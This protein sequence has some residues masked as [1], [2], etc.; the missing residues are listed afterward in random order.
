MPRP[1]ILLR[2]L[3]LLLALPAC[4][5]AGGERP[6][7]RPDAGRLQR[8]VAVLASDAYEGRGTG[9]PGADSAAAWLVRRYRALGIAPGV[10][11]YL[12]PFTVRPGGHAGHVPLLARN[13]VAVIPGTDAALR[14][15]Y[16]VLGAHYDHLGRSKFGAND[17]EAGGAIRNGADDNAS[18]TAAVVELARLLQARPT[19][20]SVLLVHFAAEELGLLGSQHFVE[21]PPVP[22]DSMQAMI[23]L[24][25]VGRLT[26]DRLVVHGVGTAT[27]LP[28]I[29][30]SA[31]ARIA[32]P[33][34]IT[35]R[36]EGF[37]PS[38]HASFFLRRVPVLHLF[39]NTHPD[40][41][42]ATD[43]AEKLNAPGTARVVALAY[44]IARELGD[45]PGRL[46]FA[47]GAQPPAIGVRPRSQV[48]LGSVPDMAGDAGGRGLRLSGVVPGSPAEAAGLREG[49]VVVELGGAAVTDLET[50]TSALYARQPGET[51]DIVVLRRGARETVRVTL[52]RRGDRRS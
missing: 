39:T 9:T 22:L 31:N 18:G 33:L 4:R 35:A 46:T 23:N 34:A 11:D 50:Y 51:V 28:A 48:Y 3:P 14:G 47:R 36:P 6:S 40:Y 20:R 15:Q 37:G 7:A 12:Q 5:H 41:H 2:V 45:R 19:R 49:D 44:E 17:P 27:E 16:V 52:A 25:M 26:D 29:V 8:D 42:E 1:S 21:S 13:V 38:D 32:A 24:D 30:D 10:P 43:D